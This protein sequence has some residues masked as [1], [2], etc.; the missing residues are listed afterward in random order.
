[1][2]SRFKIAENSFSCWHHSSA[3]FPCLPD[4]CS[5]K[6][7]FYALLCCQ[8]LL[9]IQYDVLSEINNR[10][11]GS[12]MYVTPLHRNV[13]LLVASF[14]IKSKNSKA[15]GKGD[16]LVAYILVCSL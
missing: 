9:E 3:G 1:M 6:C 12:L 7:I 4:A 5:K 14:S 10:A 8:I 11:L 13:P 16:I 15:V 2:C